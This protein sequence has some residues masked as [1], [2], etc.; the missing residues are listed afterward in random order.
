[1]LAQTMI[2]YEVSVYSVP[3]MPIDEHYAV[4]TGT[5]PAI[6]GTD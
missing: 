1:M 3:R 6:S 5:E 4:L 2:N